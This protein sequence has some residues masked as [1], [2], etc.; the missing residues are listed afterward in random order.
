M[1]RQTSRQVLLRTFMLLFCIVSRMGRLE[2]NG[3]L[4]T[5]PISIYCGGCDETSILCRFLY[6]GL[7]LGMRLQSSPVYEGTHPVQYYLVPQRSRCL[8]LIE[9]T[10]LDDIT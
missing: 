1:T 9:K 2:H 3:I 8:G 10:S 6:D 5:V 7:D 4:T